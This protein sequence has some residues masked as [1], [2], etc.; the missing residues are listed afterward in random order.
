MTVNINEK[1]GEASLEINTQLYNFDKIIEAA[2]E[3]TD[4]CWIYLDGDPR[5]KINVKIKPKSSE[6]EPKEAANEFYNFILG[7]MKSKQDYL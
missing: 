1:Y 2:S 7:L 4:S 6:I 5:G 3:F